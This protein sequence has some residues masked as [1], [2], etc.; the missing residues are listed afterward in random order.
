MHDEQIEFS[1]ESLYELIVSR[2]AERPEGS[3]TTYLFDKG[4]EKI[5]KKVGEECSEVL[6][7]SMKRNRDEI[8]YETADL[9]YHMLVLMCETG[10]GPSDIMDELRRRHGAGG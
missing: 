10:V 1:I 5:L 4:L 7:A 3:Y 6:I 2:K 9:C 8:I